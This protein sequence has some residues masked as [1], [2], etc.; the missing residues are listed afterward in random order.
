MIKGGAGRKEKVRYNITN[1]WHILLMRDKI[2]NEV[3]NNE[4][5]PI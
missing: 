3:L 1:F 2:V 4:F 5:S